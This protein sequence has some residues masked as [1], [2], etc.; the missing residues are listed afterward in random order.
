MDM[1]KLPLNQKQWASYRD[2]K[3]QVRWIIASDPLRINYIL[4][5]VRGGEV[6]KSMSAKSPKAFEKVIGMPV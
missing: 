4:Y 3:G 1:I 5:E 2:E 6:K